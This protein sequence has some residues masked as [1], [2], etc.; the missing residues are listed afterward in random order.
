MA[1]KTMSKCSAC[2][3]PIQAEYEGQTTVCAYCGE[4]LEAIAQ[5]VTIPT[6]LFASTVGLAAGILLGPAILGSTEAGA[7]YLERKAREKLAK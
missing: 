3:F 2:G 4:K 5:G 6:W 7:R 1:T